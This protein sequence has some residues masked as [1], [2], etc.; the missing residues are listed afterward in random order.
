MKTVTV[1]P[2]PL[3]LPPKK[4]RDGAGH[5]KNIPLHPLPLDLL[6]ERLRPGELQELR[7]ERREAGDLVV[8]RAHGLAW[9]ALEP[10]ARE[11]TIEV[12]H[13]EVRAVEASLASGRNRREEP[14]E[15]D[16]LRRGARARRER[17]RRDGGRFPR[18]RG[19]CRAGCRSPQC[20]GAI[21]QAG[22]QSADH[23]RQGID[24]R[25]GEVPAGGDPLLRGARPACRPQGL[26]SPQ[27]CRRIWRC[28]T[29]DSLFTWEVPP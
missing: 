16:R 11:G 6:R 13:R 22:G 20:A 28:Y 9:L 25:L 3:N 2:S 24:R 21:P 26:N 27:S 19:P 5:P 23:A 17:L 12:A 10:R 18:G 15:L 8:D 4:A 29:R 1:I 7:D 14:V